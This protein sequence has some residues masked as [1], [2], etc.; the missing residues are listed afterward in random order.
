MPTAF[1][2]GVRMHGP[3]AEVWAHSMKAGLLFD[4]RFQG[5][6]REWRVEAEGYRL[7]PLLIKDKRPAIEIAV[8]VGAKELRLKGHIWTDVQVD[9]KRHSAIV[10][11]G[12]D[13]AWQ[14]TR[15]ALAATGT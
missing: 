3:I 6:H 10:I 5:W 15:A 1:G 14:K 4:W 9:G 2:D 12:G 13:T 11:K 7:D 8:S